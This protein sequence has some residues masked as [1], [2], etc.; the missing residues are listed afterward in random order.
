MLILLVFCAI[1]DVLVGKVLEEF[2]FGEE[3]LL[4][5][6]VVAEDVD[7]AE[8]ILDGVVLT[9]K[10]EIEAWVKIEVAV[11][12]DGIKV[13]EVLIVKASVE[14]VS[15]VG[16]SV[17]LDLVGGVESVVLDLVSDVVDVVGTK[18]VDERVGLTNTT[19]SL[20]VGMVVSLGLFVVV[21]GMTVVIL[22]LF[23]VVVLLNLAGAFVLSLG[24]FVE[25]VR[26]WRSNLRVGCVLN[27]CLEDFVVRSFWNI[28]TLVE[29]VIRLLGRLVELIFLRVEVPIRM[30]TRLVDVPVHVDVSNV[31]DL[32][33]VDNVGRLTWKNKK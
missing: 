24:R 27:P 18:V 15:G 19:C 10:V 28:G 21:W 20:L 4:D 25:V 23:F 7:L 14:I 2:V 13:E 5:D 9:D 22:A 29:V 26:T 30:L 11:E 16:I 8:E 3:S 33:V 17:D 6:V 31:V 32:E 12:V 1:V